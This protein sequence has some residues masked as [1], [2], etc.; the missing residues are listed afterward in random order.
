[1]SPEDLKVL[2]RDLKDGEWY[3]DEDGDIW[4]WGYDIDVNLLR[5]FFE[6][7][8]VVE[9]MAVSSERAELKGATREL[10][11]YGW[12]DGVYRCDGELGPYRRLG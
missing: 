9:R 6:S 5:W 11:Y 12:N 8:F 2:L 3:Q 4:Q 1:M 7:R 10:R